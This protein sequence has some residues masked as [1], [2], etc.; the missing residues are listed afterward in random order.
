[1]P[2][3]HTI[4][5]SLGAA[6]EV[7]P[8]KVTLALLGWAAIVGIAVWLKRGGIEKLPEPKFQGLG[9]P[10]LLGRVDSYG[11]TQTATLYV[12]LDKGKDEHNRGG[13]C[14]RLPAK[15][16]VAKVDET[17]VRTR[18]RQVGRE[19]TG[20]TRI[21]GKGWFEGRPEQS[22]A[23]EVVFIPSNKESTYQ[24]FRQNINRLAERMAKQLCQ[25]SVIV[26]HNDGRKRETCGATWWD[27]NK[28]NC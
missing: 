1:M 20:A 7:T 11:A 22:A 23:Y 5:G 10:K 27:R 9:R 15:A 25:D 6:Q 21:K 14:K 18:A 3:V 17:F 12:G 8:A 28:G 19:N 24:A 16:G 2:R 13:R 26:V 4:Q